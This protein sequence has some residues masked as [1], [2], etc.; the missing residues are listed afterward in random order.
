MPLVLLFVG[1]I[2]LVSALR[3][4]QGQLAD[5]LMQDVPHF[6]AW[7]GAIIAIGSLGFI[8][9][10][11]S[12]SRAFL[13]LILTVIILRNYQGI[14]DGFSAA[15]KGAPPTTAPQTPGQQLQQGAAQSGVAWAGLNPN[16]TNP[17][18]SPAVAANGMNGSTGGAAGFGL[19]SLTGFGGPQELASALGNFDIGGLDMIGSIL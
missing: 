13:A 11:R 18:T 15:A 5:A 8:P 19:G 10:M 12:V 14:I 4:T 17:A 3:N 7:G 1:A 6:I 2:I 9:G 16:M